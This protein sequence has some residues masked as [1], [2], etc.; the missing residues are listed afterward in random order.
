[1][2]GL[3]SPKR[4]GTARLYSAKLTGIAHNRA[5]DAVQPPAQA[6]SWANRGNAL[7]LEIVVPVIMS[8]AL[9]WWVSRGMSWVARLT[10]TALTLAVII[11]IVL[12]E[13]SG[14]F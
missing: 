14:F 4:S 1:M 10:V 7:N 11:G 6:G 12:F 13:R 9:L 5:A 2:A 8:C 3:P